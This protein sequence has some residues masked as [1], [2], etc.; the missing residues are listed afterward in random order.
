[1]EN[2]RSFWVR[3][4][5]IKCLALD[6][7]DTQQPYHLFI[8]MMGFP[9]GSASKESALNAED[10]GLIFDWEDPLEK[11]TATHSSILAWRIPWSV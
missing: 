3:I 9:C 6:I 8:I 2:E 5:Y 11:G 7:L 1:M 10:L 4:K